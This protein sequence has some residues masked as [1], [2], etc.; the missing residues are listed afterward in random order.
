MRVGGQRFLS[1]AFAS[2]SILAEGSAGVPRVSLSPAGSRPRRSRLEG[3]RH[4]LNACPATAVSLLRASSVSAEVVRLLP[5]PS[6]TNQPAER[7]YVWT[8]EDRIWKVVEARTQKI[9][10]STFSPLRA[11]LAQIIP[12]MEE[13]IAAIVRRVDAV[14]N[15]AEDEL[16]GKED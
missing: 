4:G 14:V 15:D 1:S 5:G 12:H 8:I 10:E 13:R 16:D 7:T 2:P 3:S 9:I 11:D 6:P